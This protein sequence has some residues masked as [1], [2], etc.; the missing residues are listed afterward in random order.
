MT[1]KQW[2]SLKKKLLFKVKREVTG[3][4]TLSFEDSVNNCVLHEYHA[5][6]RLWEKWELEVVHGIFRTQLREMLE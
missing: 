1:K 2:N 6:L 3:S 4:F 5:P